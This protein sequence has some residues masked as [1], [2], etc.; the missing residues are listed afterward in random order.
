[1]ARAKKKTETDEPKDLMPIDTIKSHAIFIGRDLTKAAETAGELS[2]RWHNFKEAG[3]HKGLMQLCMKIKNMSP[4][5]RDDFLRGLP[6][7]LTAFD[8]EVTK[9]LFTPL[10]ET[11]TNVV[12]LMPAANAAAE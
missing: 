11:P 5:K 12:D 3:G 2:A 7:Y 6:H 1:M 8:L 9:D 4:T 10:E